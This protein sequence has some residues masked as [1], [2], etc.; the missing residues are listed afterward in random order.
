MHHGKPF[1]DTDVDRLYE[2]FT[3]MN[4]ASV[5]D[6]ADFIP[7]ALDTIRAV[8]A[9]GLKVGS[10]TGYN[11]AIMEVVLPIAA[12]AGYSPDNLVCAGDLPQGRPS[13]LMMYR[14]FADLGVWPAHTV[15]KVD[16][17]A[18]G[19][20]EGLSAGTW[21]VGLAVSGNAMGLT[22]AEWSALDEG[23]QAERRADATRQLSEAGAHYVIDTVASLMPVLDDIEQALRD[24][25]RPMQSAA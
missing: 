20:E 5:R 11:R 18:P 4:A 13:P 12:A 19:I 24:G 22:L 6:H 25:A 23:A 14:S 1:D 10:T 15:V 8:R 2:V 21:T 16:D 9:R 3:P 7:G 17:T